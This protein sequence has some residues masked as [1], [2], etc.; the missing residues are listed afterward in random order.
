MMASLFYRV[1][2]P[3]ESVSG[4]LAL[5]S[6][7]LFGLL[8]NLGFIR[9]PFL[10][11]YLGE[12][13]SDPATGQSQKDT[14]VL[15]FNSFHNYAGVAVGEN[16]AFW[17]EGFWVLFLSAAIARQKHIFPTYIKTIGYI[18]GAL[19]LIYTLEQFGGIFAFLGE[20]NVIIHAGFL[21]WLLAIAILLLRRRPQLGKPAVVLLL[22][23]YVILLITAYV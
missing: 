11:A 13:V 15:I 17:F 19:M 4:F 21:I 10:M 6:G 18:I 9:W 5:I 14:I 23:G 3:R 2:T 1:V 8:S 22:F 7:I 16:F 12:M 20:I